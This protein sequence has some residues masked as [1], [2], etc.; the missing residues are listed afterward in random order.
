MR[1]S[2]RIMSTSMFAGALGLAACSSNPSPSTDEPSGHQAA[3]NSAR[4]VPYF[5]LL[6]YE[7]DCQW[8]ACAMGHPTQ[9][10]GAC[11]SAY[12][13]S[14]QEPKIAAPIFSRPNPTGPYNCGG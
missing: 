14:E 1:S 2:L 5:A 12:G 4:G 9:L 3:A 11:G 13:C 7:G 8:Q 6:A 10:W